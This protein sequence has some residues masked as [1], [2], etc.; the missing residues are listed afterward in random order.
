MGQLLMSI[1]NWPVIAGY[2]A[3]CVIFCWIPFCDF[4]IRTIVQDHIRERPGGKHEHWS[5]EQKRVA[6]RIGILERMLYIFAVANPDVIS[7]LTA[8]VILK[9]FFGWIKGN[10]IQPPTGSIE[11]SKLANTEI[12][13]FYIY[14]IGNL[15]SLI[16]GV[17]GGLFASV[18]SKAI[19]IHFGL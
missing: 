15:L 2:L 11:S 12:H 18:I 17:V 19:K 7:I 1:I 3:A 9:S 4:L 16:T 13:E 10:P 8:V 14:V 6:R 5:P